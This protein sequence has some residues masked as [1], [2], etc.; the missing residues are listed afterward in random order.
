MGTSRRVRVH[1]H[2]KYML[3]NRCVKASA[4]NVRERR[5]VTILCFQVQCAGAMGTKTCPLFYTYDVL[6][7]N[8]TFTLDYESN[9]KML[10]CESSTDQGVV[11]ARVPVV[12][13]CKSDNSPLQLTAPA[14]YSNS[15]LQLTAP[16]HRSNSPLQLTT[17]TYRSALC[18]VSQ[19]ML[20]QSI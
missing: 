18:V 9:G 17:P 10:I 8:P 7:S 13:L 3:I 14:Y 4:V 12:V 5:S 1:V 19:R 11:H 20:H 15:P 6:V 2:V 16:T